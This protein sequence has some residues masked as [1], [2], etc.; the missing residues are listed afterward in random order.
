MQLSNPE[1]LTALIDSLIMTAPEKFDLNRRLAN[2]TR[3]YFRE[4]IR[5]QRDIDG[6]PYQGRT[7]RKIEVFSRSGQPEKAKL[8]QNNKNMLMGL[9]RSL[10]TSVTDESFE[11]GVMGVLGGIGRAHNEG[12]G[13]TFTTRMKGFY[14]SKTNRWEGGVKVKSNYQMPK[15][16]FI[17]WTPTL[18]RELLAMVNTD[19]LKNVE[20]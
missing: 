6:N 10:K 5:K 14:N 13:M 9:S 16:T 15:R 19:L 8:T 11:V 7:R 20:S 3:Q 1:Q 4:Q 18:E 2:R 12:R 17:G